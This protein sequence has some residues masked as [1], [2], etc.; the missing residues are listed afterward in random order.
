[1][2]AVTVYVVLDAGGLYQAVT[3]S[4][5]RAERMAGQ[6]GGRVVASPLLGWEVV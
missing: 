2:V 4:R 5:E 3:V 6:L 1:M